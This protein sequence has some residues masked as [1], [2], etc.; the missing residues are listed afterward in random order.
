MRALLIK[1]FFNKYGQWLLLLV[2]S[3]L[4]KFIVSFIIVCR[5]NCLDVEIYTLH[6]QKRYHKLR[7]NFF[8]YILEWPNHCSALCSGIPASNYLKVSPLSGT[9]PKGDK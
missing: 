4:D 7:S 3:D 9:S 5:I 8:F 1:S 2:L 6:G